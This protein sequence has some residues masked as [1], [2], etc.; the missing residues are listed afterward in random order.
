MM[1]SQYETVCEDDKLIRPKTQAE[2]E[3]E[4]ANAHLQM[5]LHIEDSPLELL[6]V[7]LQAWTH[8]KCEHATCLPCPHM[9]VLR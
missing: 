4:R 8:G 1:T 2:F 6:L 9:C 3:T 7:D 5:T